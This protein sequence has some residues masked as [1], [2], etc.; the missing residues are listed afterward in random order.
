MTPA[1][2]TEKQIEDISNEIGEL[3]NS[4]DVNSKDI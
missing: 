2:L 4:K 1:K 3:R